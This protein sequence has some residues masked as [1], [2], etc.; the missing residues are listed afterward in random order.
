METQNLIKQTLSQPEAIEHI[1]AL[2]DTND[3][4]KITKLAD[5]VCKH[6]GFFNPQGYTQQAGCV[7]ALREL[8]LS[9]LIN[10]PQKPVRAKKRSPKRLGEAVEEP[11]EVPDEAGK[12]NGLDLLLV[13]TDQIRTWNEIMIQD[14]PRGAGLHVGRQIKYLV[15][16][17][18]GLLGGFGFS[19]A[20]LTLQDRDEWIG[21]NNEMRQANLQYVVSM[22]RFLIRSSVSCKNLASRLLGMAARKLPHD[23]EKRYGY[24]PLLLESF[25]DK[26]Q[27]DGTCYKAANWLKLGETKGRGRQD[28]NNKK[29]ETIKDIYVY[30]IDKDFQQKIGVPLANRIE[31]LSISSGIE[32]ECWAEN[33]FAN[34]PLGDKRIIRRLIEVASEKAENPGL[35]YA[36]VV[37][38]DQSK[39][40]AYYRMIDASDDSAVNMGNILRPHRERTI[41]RMKG[42][43]TVLCIQDGSDLNYNRLSTCEGLGIIG[44]NQTGAKSKGLHLHSMLAT[45]TEGL[46]LGV[47]RSECTAPELKAEN[48]KRKSRDIPIEEK[49]TFCWI[50]GMRD[51]MNLKALMPETTLVNVLDREADFFELFD[52]QRNNCADVDLLVRAQHNRS[53]TE[54]C[55]LF[56]L[57]RGAAVKTKTTIS[58]P[59]QS[60]RAKKSKQKARPKRVARNAEVSV[61]YE[62]MELNPPSYMKGKTPIEIRIIH[63]SEDAPPENAIGLEW[64]LLTTCEIRSDADS[65]RYIKWYCLRWRIE[66]WHRVLKSGCG[67]EKLQH[68]TAERLK[69]AVAINMV[70]AWRIMLMTLLGREAPELPPD[71]LFDDLEIEMLKRYSKKKTFHLQI[72]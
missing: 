45:S 1:K 23:F 42:Q 32:S 27:F 30:P 5:K 46:P 44:N 70:I 12:I 65:L 50:E 53:T 67:I 21:W 10:L 28:R 43:A 33:E 26:S 61:R 69:R 36:E 68:K 56:D 3:N 52:D 38:G 59:R 2:L 8:E 58:V 20:A 55:R 64:F 17:E 37:K 25:I 9:N 63:V 57:V 60:S 31:A 66:D 41:Q 19:S 4:I 54:N 29:A 49:K 62:Q 71:V 39:T 13:N 51:C 40:K 47:L 18:H 7:K 6:F 34:A 14:H 11:H 16:S 22:S 48:D 15:K 24:R 72:A 35:A